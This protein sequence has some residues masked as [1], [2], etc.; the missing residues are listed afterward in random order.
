[1]VILNPHLEEEKARKA[2]INHTLMIRGFKK[3]ITAGLRKEIIKKAPVKL[4]S[5]L[6]KLDKEEEE[7]ENKTPTEQSSDLEKLTCT[8]SEAHLKEVLGSE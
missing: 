7:K 6:Q 3:F 5:V 2:L 1:M 8:A 4:F